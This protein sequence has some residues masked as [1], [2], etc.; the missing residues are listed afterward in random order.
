VWLNLDLDLEGKEWSAPRLMPPLP[1]RRLPLR[2]AKSG[3][4]VG[5]GSTGISFAGFLAGGVGG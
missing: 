4:K 1:R 2:P 5:H 3:A